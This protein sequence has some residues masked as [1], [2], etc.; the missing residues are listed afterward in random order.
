MKGSTIRIGFIGA[1][2]I[3]RYPRGI[4][5]KI[6]GVELGAASDVQSKPLELVKRDFQIPHLYRD[7]RELVKMKEIDAVRVCTPSKHH[8][9]PTLGALRS[10]KHVLVEKSGRSRDAT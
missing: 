5:K 2:G 6:E 3:A 1:G 9:I 4:L 8:G 7:W 10:G